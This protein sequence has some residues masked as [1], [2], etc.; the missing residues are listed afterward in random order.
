MIRVI[1]Y[2]NQVIKF[3]FSLSSKQK[4]MKIEEQNKSRSNCT[5]EITTPNMFF[6]ENYHPEQV[7]KI[8]EVCY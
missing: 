8:S 7:T 2:G 5:G 6:P 3:I 4:K 1:T